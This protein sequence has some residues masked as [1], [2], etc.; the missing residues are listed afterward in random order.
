VLKELHVRD[1]ALV[2]EATARFGPGLNLLTGETGSGKSLIIDALGLALGARA[3]LDQVRHGA[4]RASVEATF[5]SV[6]LQRE[7]GRR[8]IARVDGRA[9][10]PSQLRELASRLVAVHGQHEQQTLLDA[11]TQTDLLDAYAGA[12]DIRAEVATAHAAWTASVQS[13]RELEQL[14]SRGKREEEYLR[15]QLD[16]LRKAELQPGEDETLGAERNAGR[17]AARLA[18]LGRQA[19]E[20]LHDDSL[21]RAAAAVV[22]AAGLDARLAGS[23]ARLA[24]L[25]ED[26]A[27][28]TAEVR[29]YV[30]AI[31]S[32]PRRLEAIESRLAQL[33]AI[34]R[35]YGGSVDSAIQERERLAT[36]LVATEDMDSAVAAAHAESG[37]RRA[38]LQAAAARLTKARGAAARRMEKSVAA[39][40]QGLR[41]DGARFEVMLR[42]QP[43][44]GSAGAEVVEMMFSANPGEPIA[45]LS[46]VAS[47]GELARVMLAIKTVSSDADRMPTLVFDE[48]D[49]GIGGEA[50]IQVGLRLKAL[51]SRR[52][53]IVVTHLAQIA[54]FAD[55]HLVIEKS[56]GADGRNVVR[57]RELTDAVEKA[58]ELAR[59]MSGGVTAK[60]VARARELLEEARR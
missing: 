29:R 36:Q 26:I 47:G 59:M 16:E 7:L 39:E 41:L 48:V 22:S 6:V 21:A 56:P 5:D 11:A 19:L 45:P 34:K 58:N 49:A 60:A 24:S 14:R 20:A 31:D 10:S 25:A 23:A 37:R 35:K 28:V 32:D 15:W 44:V 42:L 2:A 27:D 52:Q 1:L 17:H 12:L 4:E 30:E 54:S 55:H 40:L 51:G 43:E 53:V 13:L 9:S 46:R 57:V 50:A 3:E 38:D 33:D 18:E 8:S